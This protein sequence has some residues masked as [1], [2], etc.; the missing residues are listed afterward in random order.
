MKNKKLSK[1]QEFANRISSEPEMYKLPQHSPT[2]WIVSVNGESTRD[3]EEVA[4]FAGPNRDYVIKAVNC[5]QEL[6][7]VL[8]RIDEFLDTDADGTL[9]GSTMYDD[10]VTFEKMVKHAI[11]KA[12][13]KS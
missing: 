3:L 5:H 7:E 8:K 11:A 12:E 9:H 4:Y 13:G 10:N 6:L 1:G 2:P